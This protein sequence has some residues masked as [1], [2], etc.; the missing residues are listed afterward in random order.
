M[1]FEIESSGEL[2][3]SGGFN[4][5]LGPGSAQKNSNVYGYGY[6][7]SD[8]R[9]SVNSNDGDDDGYNFQINVKRSSRVDKPSSSGA[10]SG[11]QTVP[12][13]KKNPNSS[14]SG[15]SDQAKRKVKVS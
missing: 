10:S 13:M 6:R 2:D 12:W 3:I 11:N 15:G 4:S 9:S 1:S 8:K 14:S 7:G 5:V